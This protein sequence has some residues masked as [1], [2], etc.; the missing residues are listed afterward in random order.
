MTHTEPSGLQQDKGITSK[1]ELSRRQVLHSLGMSLGVAG[2]LGLTACT[3]TGS[4]GG[5]GAAASDTASPTPVAVS[6]SDTY[7]VADP[8]KVTYGNESDRQYGQ[9]WIPPNLP[10]NSPAAVVMIIHGG[11]WLASSNLTYMEPLAKSLAAHGA[12]AWNIE[13]RGVHG[14]GGWPQT[15]TDV[16]AAMDLVPNLTEH[17]GSPVDST[18]FFITGHSA[19]GNLAAWAAS[20]HVN[21]AGQPGGEPKIDVRGC[22]PMA[23]VYDLTLAE[24]NKDPYMIPLLGGEPEQCPDRY[25]L[26]SPIDHL[27]THR[28]FICFHGE[29]DS[30]VKVD[31]A[32][33]Y[34]AAAQQAGDNAEAVI[35]PDASHNSW[36]THQSHP[37][38]VAHDRIIATLASA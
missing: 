3:Q 21:N 38:Q 13:Y 29:N 23:G 22:F 20:R 31:Q 17:I 10:A 24:D 33:E 30:V 14:G 7:Q 5:S 4:D 8:V 15:F 34:L 36:T 12:V 32:K 19:G 16:A 9:L 37:W 27:P 25:A 35:L 11:G 6:T 2:T 28:H 26:A 18:R 1:A